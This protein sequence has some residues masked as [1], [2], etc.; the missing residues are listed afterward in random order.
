MIL[1][2]VYSLILIGIGF[3]DFR[4]IRGFDDYIIAGRTRGSV[5]I[6]FSILAS[7]TGASATMGVV[8]LAYKKGF[9]AFWW[10][11]AGA[12]GLILQGLFL[13]GRVRA[14]GA[15]TLPDM[16][17][18]LMGPAVRRIVSLI[19]VIAW[20]GIIAAQFA[21]AA[22]IV[23]AMTGYS[24]TPVMIGS[25]SVIIIYTALGGQG[26]ILKTDFLQFA[27][28]FAGIGYAL[29]SVFSQAGLPPDAHINLINSG[30]TSSDL[31]YYLL[32]IGGSYVVC[33]VIYSRVLSAKDVKTARNSVLAAGC[34]LALISILVTLI[35][36]WAKYNLN[37]AES[38][39]VLTWIITNRL[40]P[41]AGTV[42]VLGLL[43]AVV[44]SADTCLFVT[45]S[46][47]ENDLIR[48]KS[49][50]WTRLL[51]FAFGISGI[52][53]TLFTTD[54]IG[55]LTAA[56]AVFTSGAVPPIIAALLC[57]EGRKVHEGLASVA[58][59]AGGCMGLVSSISGTGWIALTGFGISVILTLAAFYTGGRITNQTCL[60][61]AEQSQRS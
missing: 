48:R 18:K 13:S 12:A 22:K 27:V 28:L 59:I 15:L 7:V 17:E 55:L 51:V 39:D 19:I 53:M 23:S 30:F 29:Y 61:A 25:S 33:P 38:E 60:K 58:I 47:V 31:L 40:S 20:T 54:I 3:A 36:V 50:K 9:P 57:K 11:G 5:I 41:L 42:L 4:R 32:I 56:A 16:T 2:L 24:F 46:I 43:S 1:L 44:S 49:V 21:A 8:T 45:A 34:V 35:G 52:I 14:T 26:S 37:L 10:L 6:T